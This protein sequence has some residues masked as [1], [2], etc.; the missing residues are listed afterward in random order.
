MLSNP[1]VFV[2]FLN[3]LFEEFYM[4]LFIL[5][6]AGSL[7]LLRLPPVVASG[8]YSLVEVRG[9]PIAEASLTAESGLRGARASV[10]ATRGLSSCSLWA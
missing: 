7:V 6:C 8:S 2:S 4:Y 10:A 9:L 1:H 5:G 3:S